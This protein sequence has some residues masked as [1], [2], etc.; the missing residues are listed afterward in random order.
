MKKV[1]L[2]LAVLLCTAPCF[3]QFSSIPQRLELVEVEINE[4]ETVLEVFN[5]PVEGQNHYYLSVGHLGD[6]IIKN[7]YLILIE[8]DL[9]TLFDKSAGRYAGRSDG[10][11]AG[12]AGPVQ[13]GSR[14]FDRR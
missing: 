4:G 14:E 5:S 9:N 6:L 10:T 8:F 2:I 13:G 1:I 3:A 7:I 11:L 12:L